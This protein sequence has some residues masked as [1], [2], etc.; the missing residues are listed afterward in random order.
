MITVSAAQTVWDRALRSAATSV[1]IGFKA[2]GG[3]DATMVSRILLI[4]Q[5]FISNE[6]IVVNI[7]I[8]TSYRHCLAFPCKSSETSELRDIQTPTIADH[9]LTF[10]FGG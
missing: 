10:L 3:K 5:R 6:R 4:Q 7:D 9:V 8:R 1:A 2:G